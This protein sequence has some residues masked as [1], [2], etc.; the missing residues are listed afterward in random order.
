MKQYGIIHEY[1]VRTKDNE[2]LGA[3]DLH[4]EGK[5]LMEALLDLE[6]CNDDS[7]DSST[8][9]DAA[10]GTLIA[11]LLVSADSTGAAVEKFLTIVRTATHA[12]GAATPGWDDSPVTFRFEFEPLNMQLEYV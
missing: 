11:E 4:A 12:I 10:R 6:K 8:A 1:S 2:R 3:E 7:T 5:R 9:S